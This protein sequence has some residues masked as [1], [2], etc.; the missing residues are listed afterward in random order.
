MIHFE[1]AEHGITLF[2]RQSHEL[3]AVHKELH[4]SKIEL[5]RTREELSESSAQK[6]KISSQ[7]MLFTVQTF[8]FATVD[9]DHLRVSGICISF[10]QFV[11]WHF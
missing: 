3:E 7:V 1:Q 9:K 11:V 2:D 8:H 5:C 4:E 6:E 10:Q